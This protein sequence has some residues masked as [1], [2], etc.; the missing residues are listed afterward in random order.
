MIGFFPDVGASHFLNRLPG[1]L[2]VCCALTG[3]RLSGREVRDV[4]LAT[5]YIETTQLPA[6][7]ERLQGL[8]TAASS[9][10]AVANAL[11][12]HE[13]PVM[14][15]PPP[16]GSIMTKLP[17]IDAWFGHDTVEDIDTALGAAAAAGGPAGALAASLRSE[18]GRAAPTALKVSLEALRR[19]RGLSLRECLRLEFRVVAR[20][21]QR[22][23][24]YEG[25]RA[26]LLD[27]DQAP[28]WEPPTLAAVT[29][30]AVA[31]F[32]A[33]LPEADELALGPEPGAPPQRPAQ[34][35]RARM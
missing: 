1:R 24:F 8:G 33:P 35:R 3:L 32:F 27:K 10:D 4:G 11:R 22:G 17:L 14:L 7:Q 21:M 26:L 19:A 25:V 13:S 15:S 29:P 23:D 31:A 2:G 6:L 5:H 28:A 20:F 18:M 9:L 16:E 34:Q 30:D 12:E